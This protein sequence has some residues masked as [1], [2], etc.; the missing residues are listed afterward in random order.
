MP[1]RHE[2][3]WSYRARPA[4]TRTVLNLEA[5]ARESEVEDGHGGERLD[6]PPAG[7]R[8]RTVLEGIPDGAVA[9]DV[10]RVAA[11]WEKLDA[12]EHLTPDAA[13]TVPATGLRPQARRRRVS[14]FRS[15]GPR[16][17]R[18]MGPPDRCP[19]VTG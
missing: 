3:C 13:I 1:A 6:L 11:R 9:D 16:L 5:H 7:S 17:F 15:M 2:T 4:G 14:I 10:R 19:H 12:K 18:I 8:D